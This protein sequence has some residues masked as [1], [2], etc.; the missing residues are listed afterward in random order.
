M[1]STQISHP[2]PFD[3]SN[4]SGWPRWIRRFERFRVVSGLTEKEE[5]YQVNSLLYAMGDAADDILAVL[6]LTDENKKKYDTVKEAFEQHCVGKHNVIFE[7]AQFNMRFQQDGE[8]AEAFITTV[9]KLAEHCNYRDLKEELIR[10]R[11]VVGINDRRLSEQLQMDSELTLV[12]TIQRVRQ[13]E[14]VKKQQTLMYNTAGEGDSKINLDAVQTRFQR[15]GKKPQH[16]NKGQRSD[17]QGEKECGRCGKGRRHAWKDCPAKDVECRKCRKIGHYAVACF[18]G[19]AVNTVT[20]CQSDG[21]NDQEDYA[22]LGEVQTQT[23]RPWMENILLNG[24]AINFK[25]DT[26]ADVTSIPESVFKPTRD[27]KLEKPLKKLFGPGRNPLN[28]KGCFQGKMLAKGLFTDQHVYVVAGLTQP[29]LGLPAIEAMQLVHRA[30]AVTATQPETD[31]KAAYPAVFHGLGEL[32]EPYRIELKKGAT[33]YALSTPRRVPLPLRE[34]VR[35]E[36]DRMETMGVISKVT[37]PTAWC[38]GMVVVPKPKQDKL[39]ICVDLTKLNKAVKRERH[40]L[41]SVD[42]TLAMMSEAK[43][44]TKLDARSG[45]WQIPLT[46]KSRP[47]TTFITPFGRYLFNRLPFGIKSAP[48]HFQRRMSQMLEDFEGVLC[49]ADDV[50]VYGRDRQEHDQ[51]LHSVLQKMQEEGL[52]LNEKCEFA[53]EHMIF[54]GHKVSAKGIEPDPNKTKAILQMPEPECAEDVRRLIGMANYLSKFLPQLATVTVPLKDLLRE[55]NEWVWGEPQQTAFQKLKEGLSSP[56]AL[57]KYSNAAETQ[58]AADAS[59]YGIGAVLTQKQDDG[60]WQPVTFISRGLTDTE[61]RYAQIEKEALAA[62]W[63]CERLTSYVQGLHFTLLTDHKPLVPLL[64][65]RGLDDLPPR[66]LR[67]RL[68]LLRYDYDIVH[69]PGKNLITADTL[70]RAPLQDKMSPGDLELEREVQV[71]VNAVVSS[72]PATDTRL[73][74][75]KRAQQA[76]ETCKTVSHYCLTEW[77]EKHTLR[78]DVAPYWKVRADLYLADDLLMKGERLVI[79]QALR[80][81]IMTKL[82]EGHQGISKCRSRAKESVWWPGITAHIREAVDQCETCQKYRIQYREPLMETTVP[83]RPWQ[84]VHRGGRAQSYDI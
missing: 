57:A 48:E 78:P 24:E 64:S 50:L 52:T 72:L 39:R 80:R 32:K 61:K 54:V 27:G 18:R 49:H 35:E 71:F 45:F 31:F 19:K 75:I 70:S 11:I 21:D 82:H 51:R 62:T 4:P 74:E 36:L 7:R 73:E 40:I 2:E 38:S 1:A 3:F 79:P 25:I 17:T 43:V 5:E 44:F 33:P 69:V 13:S 47:L 58:V 41:P 16:S 77:P 28:V 9:H 81:E 46:P 8:S 53:K 42:Q 68:R 14:T 37:E 26:G 63:A 10:D 67:F 59:A 76:D 65:T 83:D 55:K 12:K 34:K 15:L 30:E 6:P 22:F 60:S 23:T 29:L 56:T 84:K 66:V 20:E